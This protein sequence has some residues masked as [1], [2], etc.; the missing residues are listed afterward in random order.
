MKLGLGKYE[1]DRVL[2]LGRNAKF[3]KGRSGRAVFV[4]PGKDVTTITWSKNRMDISVRTPRART[5]GV[6][7]LSP[8]KVQGP[9][10][11]RLAGTYAVD[12]L[13]G[14]SAIRYQGR[15]VIKKGTGRP[16]LHSWKIRSVR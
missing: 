16:A 10:S 7:I 5:D 11:G 12:W 14:T 15:S 9:I 8:E 2:G 1:L 13:T 4:D 6:N 3:L